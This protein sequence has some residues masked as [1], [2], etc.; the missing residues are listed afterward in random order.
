MFE[1]ISIK[2]ERI[3][4]TVYSVRKC[5]GLEKTEFLIYDDSSGWIWMPAEW[6]IPIRH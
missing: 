4:R 5:G 1:V 6:Y 3:K 2:D